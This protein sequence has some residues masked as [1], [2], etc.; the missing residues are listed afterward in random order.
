MVVMRP[1]LKDDLPSLLH[2]LEHSSVGTRVIGS[3][4][5]IPDLR[6]FEF[7]TFLDRDF[8]G[9][10]LL[11]SF[12]D[13]ELVGASMGIRR[14]WKSG[15]EHVGWIKFVLVADGVHSR[16]TVAGLVGRI[17]GLLVRAGVSRIIFGS[18][19]PRYF[20]PGVPVNDVFLRDV[21]L[22]LGWTTRSRRRSLILRVN[23]EILPVSSSMKPVDD[24]FYTFTLDDPGKHGAGL[25]MVRD[26]IATHFGRSWA[27]EFHDGIH[28]GGFG[29]G[30]GGRGNDSE[31]DDGRGNDGDVGGFAVVLS[32]KKGGSDG[33]MLGFCCVNCTNPGWLG[34]VG[35]FK[36][37]RGRGLGRLLLE[38]A[39]VELRARKVQLVVIPWVSVDNQRF[40]EAVLGPLDVVEFWKMERDL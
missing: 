20:L 7:Q 35:V 19:S 25:K 33:G 37:Y 26:G 36:G 8:R 9:D 34:P 3:T 13:G 15:K 30:N 27:M 10:L 14:P 1:L 32:S 17:E 40:Y 22:D 23:G 2:L 28:G 5:I 6:W 12:R 21:L 11:G 38:G 39:L 16:S 31:G 24:E 29:G 4:S 18:S